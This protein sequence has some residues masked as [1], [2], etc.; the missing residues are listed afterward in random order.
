M[1]ISLYRGHTGEP[2]GE[3]RLPGTS[4]DSKRWLWKWACLSLWGLY[5]GNLK[6]G[7]LTGKPEGY[8]KEGSGNEQ[9]L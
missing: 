1:G 6:G 9:P 5:E 2:G 3:V 7:L 8:A 4:R